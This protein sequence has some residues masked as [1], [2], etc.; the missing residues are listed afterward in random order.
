MKQMLNVRPSAGALNAAL[1]IARLGLGMMMLTHGLPKLEKLMG[2][3]PAQFIDFMG[4]GPGISLALVVFAEVFC[5]IL[6]ILGLGTRYAAIPLLITMLVAVFIAHG[7][8]PFGKKEM[9]LL[10]ATG[11]SIL[12]LLGSGRYSVDALLARPNPRQD[13]LQVQPGV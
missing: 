11:Y 2:P 10:Y 3:E 7:S 1:L 8:D 13:S 12:M 6:I 4:L 5:S 9:G